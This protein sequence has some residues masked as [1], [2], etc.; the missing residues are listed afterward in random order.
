VNSEIIYHKNAAS[1]SVTDIDVKRFVAEMRAAVPDS[2]NDKK[3]YGNFDTFPTAWTSLVELE[4]QDRETRTT[5][6]DHV[7]IMKKIFMKSTKENGAPTIISLKTDHFTQNDYSVLT[8]YMKNERLPVEQNIFNRWDGKTL[9][10]DTDNFNLKNIKTAISS[11]SSG[12]NPEK[13]EEMLTMYFKNISTTLKF[14]KKIKSMTGKHDWVKQI[15][16]RTVKI[17]YDL[18][19]IFEKDKEGMFENADKKIVIVTE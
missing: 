17:S 14:E 19:T 12:N 13:A 11:K 6:P 4:R 18:K 10:I 15:D 9:T 16:D 3:K 5:N 2:L 8:D 1:T 7:R